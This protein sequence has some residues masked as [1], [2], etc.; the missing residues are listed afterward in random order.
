ML[1]D[2]RTCFCNWVFKSM[3]TWKFFSNEAWLYLSAYVNTQINHY[4][5]SENSH[6]LHK[7][8]FHDIND[9]QNTVT[10]TDFVF[11]HTFISSLQMVLCRS[12]PSLSEPL[13]YEHW[14][15]AGPHRNGILNGKQDTNFVTDQTALRVDVNVRDQ[16]WKARKK[17]KEKWEDNRDA[18]TF[19]K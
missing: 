2:A 5:N 8:L 7:H 15:P 3:M 10:H 18:S 9:E 17:G 12:S 19:G 11:C 1:C 6:K 14:S 4:W 13:C 16:K